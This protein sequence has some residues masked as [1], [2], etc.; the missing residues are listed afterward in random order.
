M[1]LEIGPAGDQFMMRVT[2]VVVVA[3]GLFA[4]TAFAQNAAH[5]R[6]VFTD[7]KCGVCHS[8]GGEGNKKGP[9]D[10][11]G[12]KL[13]AAD[14]RAWIVSAPDMAAKA[15]ADR[16]PPMKAYTDLPKEDL[17]DLV[18]YLQTLKKK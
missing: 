12:A 5:G 10:D 15:K 2:F 4:G 14:I 18:A 13:T 6:Q 8:V 1:F 7:S 16:K 11:V 9:I 3:V 17:D